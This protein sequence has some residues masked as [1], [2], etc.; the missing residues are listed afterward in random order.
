[1]NSP[2]PTSHQALTVPE[3]MSALRISRS[4]VYD[5]IRSKRLP[6]FT[7]GRLRR[8]PADAVTT[9]MK[10]RLEEAA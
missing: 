9:Y 3:V 5:L 6:S 7:E 2:L 10:N 8:V 1:M 4:K